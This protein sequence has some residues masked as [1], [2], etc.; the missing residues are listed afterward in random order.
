MVELSIKSFQGV[1]LTQCQLGLAPAPWDPAKDKLL[2]DNGGMH[3]TQYM[4]SQKCVFVFY[5]L[6]GMKS[7]GQQPWK[8]GLHTMCVQQAEL[9]IQLKFSLIGS[10]D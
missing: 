2:I 6:E 1:P 8:N 5:P 3:K 4:S 9:A 10:N 7:G